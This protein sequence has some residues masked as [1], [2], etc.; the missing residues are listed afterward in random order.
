MLRG[1]D[2]LMMMIA[3][4]IFSLP[5]GEEEVDVTARLLENLY[6]F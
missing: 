3:S 1:R 6:L 5:R 2:Y 4:L